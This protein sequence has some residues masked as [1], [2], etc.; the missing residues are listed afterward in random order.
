[1]LNAAA[2]F[3]SQQYRNNTR[4]ISNFFYMKNVNEIY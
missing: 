4:E 2:Y 3:M 1:M